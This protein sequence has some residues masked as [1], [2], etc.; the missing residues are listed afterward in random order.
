MR[1]SDWSSD[2]CSSDLTGGARIARGHRVEQGAVIGDGIARQLAL[3][4][5]VDGGP[6]DRR[7]DRAGQRDHPIV[8]ARLQHDHVELMVGETA[9]VGRSEERSVGKECVSTVE[10][11][12]WR[13]I[14]KKK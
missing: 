7:H 11:G 3:A 10:F 14:L 9:G 13:C 5:L 1:I 2:V 4:L 8:A 6:R 12:W